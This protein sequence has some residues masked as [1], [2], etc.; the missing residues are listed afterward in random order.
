M[1]ASSDTIGYDYDTGGFYDEM[2]GPGGQP[3]SGAVALIQM[4]AALQPG[5]L[6]RRQQA[7]EQTL[8]NF[9]QRAGCRYYLGQ[10]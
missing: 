8:L 2:F 4:M 3:R 6:L 5:E 9:V 10:Q 7:A 1:R